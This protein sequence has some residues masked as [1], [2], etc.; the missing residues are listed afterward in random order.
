MMSNHYV[1]IQNHTK[2]YHLAEPSSRRD[3]YIGYFAICDRGLELIPDNII[4]DD[5]PFSDREHWEGICKRCLNVV[6]AK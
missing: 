6:H 4:S 5:T 2:T 1:V 3:N